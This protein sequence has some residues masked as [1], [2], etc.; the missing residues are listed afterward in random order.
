MLRHG[1]TVA[2]QQFLNLRHVQLQ[3]I[4]NW[5]F[6]SSAS[7]SVSKSS[8]RPMRRHPGPI[9]G[10]LFLA[11]Q[12]TLG[13]AVERTFENDDQKYLY[14]WG[15]TFGRQ[16]AAAGI[17]A[18]QD[19]QWVLQGLQ[20]QVDRTAPEFG[21]E[22]PS[23]L[24]N[25]LLRRSNAAAEAEA[26]L[27][28]EYVQAMATEKGAQMTASGLVFTMIAK[29]RGAAPS[30]QSRVK[31][32]YTGTLRDGTVFD[33]SR[34][35]NQPLETRLDKVIACWTEAIPMMRVGGKAKITC[36]AELAYGPRGNRNIPGG[37]ALTFE[38][39]LL[40]VEN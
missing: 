23:L 29:G 13:S 14:Y 19:V 28:G 39:E 31:V 11:L 16:L 20:D 37:A 21:A 32:H 27:S 2:W 38:V 40:G 18:P 8:R 4:T 5:T 22:Y 12:P 24:S 10:L 7:M 30:A 17:S 15:T 35:R 26:K 9:I 1:P 34:T 6:R 33:S 25:Y 3:P 36:P